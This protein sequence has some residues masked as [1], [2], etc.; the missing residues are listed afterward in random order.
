MYS[1]LILDIS[2]FLF[3]YRVS[4]AQIKIEIERFLLIYRAERGAV[5]E[6]VANAWL[7]VDAHIA[8]HVE[9]R[10]EGCVDG[11]LPRLRSHILRLVLL[12]LAVY[13]VLVC[14]LARHALLC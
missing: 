12:L 2:S 4:N 8:E 10:S 9:L 14:R 1:R 3:T 13:H 7:D 11:E 5:V 6:I